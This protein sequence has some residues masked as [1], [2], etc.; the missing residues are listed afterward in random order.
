MTIQEDKVQRSV[1]IHWPDDVVPDDCPLFAHNAIVIASPA[2]KIWNHLI[3][4]TEWPTWYTN[5]DNVVVHSPD[6][7]LADGVVFDWTTFGANIHSTVNEFEPYERIGW[8]AQPTSG[9]PTTRGSCSRSTTETPT[10]SWRRPERVPT[11]RSSPSRTPATCTAAMPCG[12]PASNFSARRDESVLAGAS[13][14]RSEL[15][16]PSARVPL[17]DCR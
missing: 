8:R 1:D 12:L 13:S 7:V 6:S 10:S 11:R 16:R 14:S 9:A 3:N 2:E 4:P 17:P 15:V 5:A